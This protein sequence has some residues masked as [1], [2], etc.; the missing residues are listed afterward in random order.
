MVLDKKLLHN[1]SFLVF[2]FI[3]SFGSSTPRP[4]SF[5]FF[6]VV[7]FFKTISYFAKVYSRHSAKLP[8][9]IYHNVLVLAT[10][11]HTF[12]FFHQIYDQVFYVCF[13]FLWVRVYRKEI[14]PNKRNPLVD[15]IGLEPMPSV[16]SGR[17]SN[18]LIYWSI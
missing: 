5:L 8:R 17:L 16:L 4:L 6:G 18:Q 14:I 10:R 12:N 1:V 3:L 9:S 11:A 15:Q 2:V 13:L 7:T